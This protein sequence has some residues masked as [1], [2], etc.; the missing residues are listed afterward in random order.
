[1]G[2]VD[3]VLDV[4]A[5]VADHFHHLFAEHI[6]IRLLVLPQEGSRKGDY[7][8][9]GCLLEVSLCIAAY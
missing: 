8:G 7:V 4:D 3:F 2:K 9:G 5:V 1:M 6:N